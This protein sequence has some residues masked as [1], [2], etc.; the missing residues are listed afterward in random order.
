MDFVK[1]LIVCKCLSF[2]VD[3]TQDCSRQKLLSQLSVEQIKVLF[4]SVQQSYNIK[5]EAL[6]KSLI[7]Q[8]L[9][10]KLTLYRSL[11]KTRVSDS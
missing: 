7:V 9:C 6:L 10:Q 8:M 3:H 1:V 4:P 5:A 2:S 11:E